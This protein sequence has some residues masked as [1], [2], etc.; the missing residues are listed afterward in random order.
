MAWQKSASLPIFAI[1]VFAMQKPNLKPWNQQ[2][3]CCL[4]AKDGEVEFS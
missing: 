4:S 3:P 2:H 1:W